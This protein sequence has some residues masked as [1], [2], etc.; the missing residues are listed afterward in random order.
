MSMQWYTAQCL[1]RAVIH[2]SGKQ[3]QLLERRFFLLRADDER[4]AEK[5]ALDLAKKK[6]HSYMASNGEKVEWVLQQ[7]IDTKVI[8]AK[9][10][11][12]GTEVFYEYVTRRGA[13]VRQL[14]ARRRLRS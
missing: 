3:G 6:Q 5:R 7:V 12:E 8:M 10:L 2:G 13:K 9:R 14:S 4:S 1:F 11:E